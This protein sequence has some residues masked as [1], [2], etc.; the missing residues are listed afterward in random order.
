MKTHSTQGLGGARI[1]YL[2]GRLVIARYLVALQF[3]R[4]D[5]PDHQPLQFLAAHLVS[6]PEIRERF[7]R[8]AGVVGGTIVDHEN[9]R[10]TVDV[11]AQESRYLF[12]RSGQPLF[13]VVG[14][15]DDG[16]G[17]NKGGRF[18]IADF[19]NGPVCRLTERECALV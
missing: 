3:D 8:E 12:E 7:E 6:D 10:G 1:G 2:V 16:K 18:G 13:F 11:F 15:D 14:R 5:R 19:I 4:L 9:L 17:G